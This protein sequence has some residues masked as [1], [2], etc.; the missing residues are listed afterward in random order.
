MRK[1]LKGGKKVRIPASRPERLKGATSEEVIKV[2]GEKIRA[3]SDV[4]KPHRQMVAELE[5]QLEY[6]LKL[7]MQELMKI[8]PVTVIPPG[9]SGIKRKKR[10]KKKKLSNKEF[11][12]VLNS[13]SPEESERLRG[14]LEKLKK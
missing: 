13:L 2:A 4:L 5:P 9:K 1:F 7:R 8:T 12:I 10:V 11:E 3:L 6:W 14:L